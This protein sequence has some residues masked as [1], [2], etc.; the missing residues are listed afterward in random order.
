MP[1]AFMSKESANVILSRIIGFLF[2]LILL[3]VGNVIIPYI[4]NSTYTAAIKFLVSNIVLLMLITFFEMI[5]DLFWG[6][7]VPFNILAPITSGLLSIFMTT[8][9]YNLWLFIDSYIK[10][11]LIIP[12]GVIIVIVFLIVII[13]GYII[14]LSGAAD[15]TKKKKEKIEKLRKK[16]E[17]RLN[18][19]EI[20]WEN[21][22]DEFKLLFYN[23]GRSINELFEKR[24]KR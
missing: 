24:E 4:D 17:R 3:L 18:K 1:L 14:I 6:F 8:F 5:K 10:S 15:S 21:V 12:I 22:E 20:E 9:F 23:I 11:K 2:F 16:D 7:R 19:R 13:F